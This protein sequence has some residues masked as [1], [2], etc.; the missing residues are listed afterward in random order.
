MCNKILTAL[1]VTTLSFPLI[2]NDSFN[3]KEGSHNEQRLDSI[4]KI[5]NSATQGSVEA[6]YNLALIYNNG[7]GVTKDK[8]RAHI[9]FRRAAEQGHAQA[10]YN[11]GLLYAKGH[12]VHKNERMA[13][14]WYK[15]SV[16][17]GCAEAQYELAMMYKE[18]VKGYYIDKETGLLLEKDKN[19]SFSLLQKSAKQGY[20]KAQL[21]L[22]SMEKEQVNDFK[23]AMKIKG[24]LEER[25]RLVEAFIVKYNA[26]DVNNMLPR[27]HQSADRINAL[28]KKQQIDAH[29]NATTAHKLNLFIHEYGNRDY[30]NLVNIAKLQLPEL[31]SKEKIKQAAIEKKR[32]DIVR[33]KLITTITQ[34][35]GSFEEGDFTNCGLVAERKKKVALVQTQDGVM[36]L[37][38][39]Q[40]YPPGIAGCI[41]V[42]GVYQKPNNLPI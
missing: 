40:L 23:K 24:S 30:A 9:W 29:K 13:I 42:N 16:K 1:L 8:E 6:Q 18:G 10:Q 4:I 41:I 22:S 38:I 2:A 35:R 17:Q 32:S 7:L 39:S 15:K 5:K 12:G 33:K 37:S 21:S 26:Y 11:L 3:K 36:F 34:F 25:K 31:R 14:I 27:A 28:L 20:E 19:K